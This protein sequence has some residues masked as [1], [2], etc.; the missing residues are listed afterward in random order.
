MPGW[1]E[2]AILPALGRWGHRSGVGGDAGPRAD[3]CGDAHLWAGANPG[4]SLASRL[5]AA[6]PKAHSGIDRRYEW[7]ATSYRLLN[8]EACQWVLVQSHSHEVAMIIAAYGV[9]TA[10]LASADSLHCNAAGGIL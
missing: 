6:A 5:T 10:S 7:R 9:S 4:V 3:H 8:G 1:V 2:E